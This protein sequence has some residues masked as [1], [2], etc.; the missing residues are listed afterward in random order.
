M[1][2]RRASRVSP[3]VAAITT[4]LRLEGDEVVRLST[5]EAEQL[6]DELWLLVGAARGALSAAA[7]VLDASRGTPRVD[8]DERESEL[9]RRLLGRV[10]VQ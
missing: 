9:A 3:T 4:Q 10:R 8:L 6:Y 2:V 5:E 1:Q 7:K